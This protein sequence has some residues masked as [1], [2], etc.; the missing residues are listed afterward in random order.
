M[1]HNPEFVQFLLR[2]KRATYAAGAAPNGS[3]RP[4]SSDLSYSE[5]EF[6]YL[7]SYL[8]SRDFLGEEAI[9]FQGQPLW[10]MNYHGVMLVEDVPAG[11]AE[12][13]HAALNAVPFEAPYRGPSEVVMNGFRYICLW[14]GSLERFNGYERIEHLGQPI[15]DLNFHGGK[16]NS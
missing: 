2:A 5:G 15:Y 12:I 9:W 1:L 6:Q 13:L 7:D 10:G 14:H 4:T 3:S 16:I 11:F 8:G